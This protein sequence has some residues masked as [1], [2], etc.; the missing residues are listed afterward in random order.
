MYGADDPKSG[1][2]QEEK[3][4]VAGP[5]LVQIKPVPLYAT[6]AAFSAARTRAGVNGAVRIRTP[7]ASK[8]AFAIA[9]AAATV[10]GSPTP[11]VLGVAPLNDDRRHLRA[12]LKRMI[13]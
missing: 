2:P 7:V 11:R 1:G 8:N 10:T 6:P 5:N 4:P 13:G 12:S 9:A 3:G